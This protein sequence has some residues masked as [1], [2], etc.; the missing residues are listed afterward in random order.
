MKAR[1]QSL[2]IDTPALH[3]GQE[4]D[5]TTGARAVPICQTTSYQFRDS[6]DAADL[7]ALAES[8]NIYT[9]LMNPTTDVLE[10]RIALIDGGGGA[11]ATSSGQ[12]AIA[13]ALLNLARVGDEVV[14]TDRLYG[15]TYTLF[16]YTFPRLGV[17]VRFVPSNDP[18][19]LEAAVT[20]RS[21][22]F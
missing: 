6:R 11:L 2:H 4:A 1:E 22:V 9:R 13:L 7:F 19:A 10:K 5:P 3:G 14:S 20:E 16:H 15:G 8:G 12:A 17:R 18:A 21:G